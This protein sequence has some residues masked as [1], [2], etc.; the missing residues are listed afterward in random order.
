MAGGMGGGFG[1]GPG[2]GGFGGGRFHFD[3]SE[4]RPVITKQILLRIARYFIPYWKL[5]LLL[6]I[7]I[8]LTASLGLVPP[9]L[10][11]RIIDVALPGK[12]IR[13]LVL[14][15][16]ASFGATAVSG[17]IL[18]GQNY[19]NSWISKHIIQDV[20]NAMFRHL[21]YM[22][23]RFFSDVRPGEIP[24]RMNNDIGGIESIFAGTFVQILQNIFVFL[25]TAGI[26][27]YTNWKLAAVSMLILPLFVIP[28]R[29]VGKVR[30]KIAA[31]TQEKLAELNTVIQETLSLGGT[32]LVKLFTKE[33]QQ[34][35]EFE[36][37]NADVTRLQMK[38]SL[39]GRWF[40]MT[41]T[42][43]VSLGPLIIY[44]IG[45]ILLIRSGEITIGSIVMFVA[46]LNRLYGPVTSFA[47]I[48]VDITRSLALFDRIFQYLDM[49]QEIVDAP[50]AKDPGTVR[51]EIRFA[52][53]RFSYTD[54]AVTL[55]DINIEIP[56]GRMVAFV[57]PSGAGKTTITYLL[58]RL[59]DIDAGSI[60]I[61][62][63]DI[64]AMTL[65]SL[66][67]QIGIVTQDTY[68]LNAT[69]RRNLLFARDNAGEEE[70]VS[71]CRTA[72]IHDF[73]ASLPDGYDTLVGERGIKL[74]GGEKQRLAIARALLKDPRIV[75]LDEA[76]SSL[77]SVSESL[78]QDA[79]G[80][81]LRGRTS[82][83]IAHRL[84]TIMAADC[85]YVVNQGR[86]EESGTHEEL[87]AMNGLY[88]ELYEKQFRKGR[89]KAVV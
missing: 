13:L 73:I 1:G 89:G 46:L 57:G 49:E 39:A 23:I 22:S 85:I 41:I 65:E 55:R 51:G 9:V 43:I 69:I 34:Q 37:V 70:I 25:T 66:R 14:L 16:A 15:V 35:A 36:K 27:F 63:T 18:V 3:D 50:D 71:A 68:M 78:I 20:R 7:C 26:L 42:T 62:G 45:G 72:N 28:T 86:I 11:R 38:E 77:D 76:T 21:Q 47:N 75:I 8:I 6:V 29:K 80:P 52:D 17:L 79:I 74:S 44:L 12:Q 84:S 19:L 56:A 60:T 24:S 4:I 81:L 82:L 48:S 40:F 88:R 87:Y 31:R 61:D 58:P 5:L 67:R 32:F 64:R 33:K 10:T 30:W 59:Y 2:G 83:V 54:K 53:V